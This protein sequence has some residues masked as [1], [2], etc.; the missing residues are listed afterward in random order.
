MQNEELKEID[1][2]A[3]IINELT[4]K[5]VE[6]VIPTPNNPPWNG[7]MGI[8]VWIMS[9]VFIAIFPILFLA[10][11]LLKQSNLF[12]DPKTM[13]EFSI[14]DP[15]AIILQL[16]AVIPAHIFTLILAWFVV[17]KYK[18][19]SFRQTL[20]WNLG[21][22]RVW[23]AF[24]ITVFFLVV[25]GLLQTYLPSQQNE[26]DNIINSSRTAVY[27]VAFFATFTAPIVEEVVYRGIL[28]SALQRK[29]GIILAVSLVTILFV[30]V[31]VPQ[32]SQNNVPDYSAIILLLMLSLVLTLIRVK[33][34]NLLPCI[35][36][37]TV[38]NGIQSVFLILQPYLQ[39][40]S[41]HYLPKVQENP[42]SIF[43]FLK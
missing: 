19:Y 32:Y 42:G 37:H 9:I 38:F 15:T 33:T 21:S 4:E 20:G 18:K 2:N 11:Y 13:A 28:Y 1:Y 39:S 14:T 29:F 31:H 7:W 3:P 6:T 27:L 34:K 40:L 36:L 5:P 35:V 25:A 41:D 23:H 10:P 12:A 17:T 24:A 8:G 26:M 30:G 22:F 16:L 43:H